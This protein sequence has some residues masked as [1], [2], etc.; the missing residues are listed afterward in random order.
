MNIEHGSFFKVR[1]VFISFHMYKK[2]KCNHVIKVILVFI[3]LLE[4]LN[5]MFEG[6]LLND[7]IHSIFS[8]L[9]PVKYFLSHH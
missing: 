1:K 7:T 6:K 5:T 9:I 3:F 8:I 4:N 2:E